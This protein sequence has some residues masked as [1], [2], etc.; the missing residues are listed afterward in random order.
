MYH[1]DL[2]PN[3][4]QAHYGKGAILWGLKRY[5]EALVAFDQALRL[6]RV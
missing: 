4:V 2:D 3:D 5:E 1:L 6:K